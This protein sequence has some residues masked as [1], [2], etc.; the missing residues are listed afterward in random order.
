VKRALLF[1]VWLLLLAAGA[2]FVQQKLVIGGDL[3]LFM[4]SPRTDAQ[5]LLMTELGE[6]PTSRLL[7][8]AIEGAPA[9]ALAETSKRLAAELRGNAD[10]AAVA[11]GEAGAD[12]VPERLL[13]YRY[14]L[15][16]RFDAAPLDGARL[17]DELQARVRDL[18]SP[19][20][21]MLEEW[22]PRDPTL[23]TLALA[24]KWQPAREPSRIDDVWF[25]RAGARALLV[26][27]TGAGAFDPERQRQAVHGIERT[28]ERVRTDPKASLVVSGPG[29]FSVLMREKTEKEASWIGTVDTVAM[30]V[31]LLIA[32]RSLGL[33]VLAALPLATAGI[34][35]MAAVTAWYGTVHGITLAFG[36]TLIGVVQDYPV[37]LLSHRHPG[38]SP[39]DTARALWAPLGTGIASTCIAYLA[40]LFSGVPGLAQLAVFTIVGLAVA[41]LSARYVLPR[42]VGPARRDPG[43]SRVLAR[44]SDSI[45]RLP[46]P[47][48]LGPALAAACVAAIVA[49]PT[50]FW[51]DQLGNLTPVPAPLL[52]RDGELRAELGTPD[53]RYLLV[54]EGRDAT[55]ALS[56]SAALDRRLDALVARSVLQGYD[57]ASR[58][59]PTPAV[60]EKRRA[61]L[62]D[63]ATLERELRAALDGLPFK[64]GVFDA[65]VADV[66]AARALPPLDA[67]ALKGTPL[68]A[69]VGSLLRER[70]SGAVALVT[71]TGVQDLAALRTATGEGV[72]L[73]D[74]KAATEGLVASQRA[75]IVRSLLVAAVVLVVVVW[76]AL[77]RGERVYRV[78]LPMTVT[79]LLIL[80][81]FQIAGVPLN[82]FHLISLVL[83]AGLGLD[84]AL[85]FE[86]AGDDDAE[87]RRTLHAL[88]VCS[89]A[90]LL[91]FT[92][93][94]LSSLPVLRAIGTTVAIGVAANF[95]L[96]LLLAR[97]AP[98]ARFTSPP[99]ESK[100]ST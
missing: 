22:L 47:L 18:A 37:H 50:P 85:F 7:L 51:D 33:T 14:L 86:R 88:L 72:T 3:R 2:W 61:A 20:G 13:P 31:L 24:E 42:L 96:G 63:R 40:F 44:L 70:P 89:A 55:E 65:F 90:T 84:Y 26:V 4:P 1:G 57:S 30:I 6:G 36:F 32:Y 94:A 73:L 76:I 58:Y 62:P 15:T 56:R 45:A 91:V 52:K 79:T 12:A 16:D 87:H 77:R 99:P 81:V 35:G 53:V 21:A 43:D 41:G 69:R 98:T 97:P 64:P 75:H 92:I 60:Q 71:L 46:R 74:L 28:F 49:I 38:E 67:A 59:L 95:V 11:N 9:D 100:A 54:V 25:D 82:L 19:A 27:E 17:R 78:L 23:E 8:I 68:E 83:A 29:A 34:A 39:L 93:L 66:E 10:F 48:W 80:A 5:R